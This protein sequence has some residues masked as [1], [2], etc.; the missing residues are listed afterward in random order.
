[1]TRAS[2]TVSLGRTGLMI[3]RLGFGTMAVG[4][5]YVMTET[6]AATTLDAARAHGIVFFDTA[7][8]YGAGLAEERLGAALARWS[9]PPVVATKVGKRLVPRGSGGQAQRETIFP[10]GHDLETVF[11][12]SEAGTHE[13]FAA[14]LARLRCERIDLVLIHDVTR[15]FHGDDGVMRRFDEAKSGA[16]PALRA[17]QSAGRITALG[18]GLKD[19]DIAQRFIE[20]CAID[21][22]LLP[23]RLTLLDHTGW[24]SGLLDLAHQRG[25]GV[26]AAAP[27]DSG[28]LAA[29]QGAAAT[30]GYKPADGA[31]R[32]RV[33]AIRDVCAAHGIALAAAALQF[34]LRHPAVAAVVTG[35]RTPA[36]IAGNVAAVDLDIPAGLWSD[37][38]ERGL[39]E[40]AVA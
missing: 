18:V 16:I 6:E 25:V 21:V 7:P 40:A 19:V 34:P 14:S 4:G 5:Q 26:I 28:I 9:P 13:M 23:G 2:E 20:E 11:D 38:A 8:Q 12:Y 3:S 27:F 10:A 32:A 35:M 24:T 31:M 29:D 30:Y 39:I 1:M 17:L 15:H 36:E 22:V 37:L 33:A